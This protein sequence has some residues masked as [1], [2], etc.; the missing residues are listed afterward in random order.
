[1]IVP[2]GAVVMLRT[3]QVSQPMRVKTWSPARAVDRA[4]F[5]MKSRKN[6]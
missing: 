2:A 4:G 3:W 5:Q 1:M 6:P